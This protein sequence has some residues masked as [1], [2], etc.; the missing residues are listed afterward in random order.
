M[1]R[2]CLIAAALGVASLSAAPAW[3]QA[4]AGIHAGEL[5]VPVNKSQVVTADTPIDRAMVGNAAIADVVPISDRS[6]YV[7][8]K[9]MGTTSLTLYDRNNRVI[10]VMDIDVGP[11]VDGL[12][13]QLSELI[14]GQP[15][16][17]RI[18]AGN[19]ILSG[20][21]TDPGAADRAAKIA[22]AYAGDKVVN[23]I[24][25]GGSQ[26]VLLEVRFAEVSRN[27][28]EELGMSGFGASD[29]GNFGAAVGNGASIVPD[30]TGAGVLQLG[31]ITDAFGVF[32]AIF[33]LGNVSVQAFLNSLERK[34]LS[35]TLAS[36]TLVALS[37]ERASFLAGG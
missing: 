29:S 31:S 4:Q 11:D 14:P 35:R 25:V 34:G 16:E 19:L 2:T 22:S 12:R 3:A 5:E 1:L 8:G 10:A 17:A 37:G 21:V 18:S 26:Q 6:V 24:S 30:P 20:M 7:L 28:G 27:V 36:P 23:L 33:D 13:G 15:I 9:T 32:S